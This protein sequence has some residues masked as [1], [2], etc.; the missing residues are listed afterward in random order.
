MQNILN[1]LTQ[2]LQQD[3]RLVIDGKLVKNKIVELALALD[4]S[5]IKLLLK[6]ASI[7]KHF[8]REVEGVLV[9]DKVE[10]QKFVSNK[11]F[12]PDSY[13]SFK[14]KIGLT[15]NGEYLT[16]AKE[17]VLVWPYKDCVLEGGQ[18][19][20]DQKRKE[21]FWNTT[22]A[23]DEIDRL[24]S[25]K[26]LTNFKR[27]DSN[28][29]HKAS[30]ITT[31][32][33]FILKGNNLLVIESLKKVFS[34]QV[35]LIYIDPPYNTGSDSFQYND[36][37]TNS[38]WLTFL[39]N[40]LHVA[41]ELMKD[42]GIIIIQINDHNQ[43]YLKCLMDEIFGR[44]NFINL[45]SIKTKSP[46]GFKTVNLGL[47]ETAEYLL[48]YG[49]NKSL[50]KYIP[51]YEFSGY[52]ENY[53]GFVKNIKDTP[54]AWQIDDLRKI[55]CREEGIDPDK[56]S[57]PYNKLKEKI[58]DMFYTNRLSK[59]ALENAE[60]VFRLTAIGDDAGKE[61]LEAKKQS[62]DNPEHVIEVKRKGLETRYI[63]NGQEMAFYSKKIR[64]IDGKR[65][66]TT[67]LTNIWTDISWEGIA[68][69]GGVKLKK[70][71]KPE[72]L[73]RRI[74]EMSTEKGDLVLDFY[75][76]SGTT[77]A[78]AHK[79]NRRYIGVEQ[80]D[81]GDNDVVSRMVNVING[82]TTGISKFSEW[83]GGGSFVYAELKKSNAEF[84]GKIETAKNTKELEKIWEQ[85]QKTGFLSYRID[86]KTINK[87]KSEFGQLTLDEQ[88]QF[89]IELL[90]KNQLYVNYSEIDD[91]D[92]N[93]SEDDKKLNRQFYSL[94]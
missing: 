56:V 41:K 88:K 48:M 46:S 89:L 24:L 18:T 85:M 33:N 47:F 34:G 91:K 84:C 32:D 37:F 27:Y 54:D 79:L 68:S 81:Y 53:S 80:L 50:F 61:T 52:D 12:L 67:M 77:T 3:K 63:L 71:K 44:E 57:R 45:I 38:T 55:L 62:I 11:Q 30:T 20:E 19:K 1:E 78:V 59:L 87:N 14:N 72:K 74:I 58:G 69:E 65:V 73:L 22:L 86:P 16:E 10:F 4:E 76:G 5:L 26:V 17:V 6:N 42:S 36:N 21:I 60:S 94:K 2:C 92:F 29:G 70:G 15:A 23:P 40:R 7:R 9:F 93:L 51:Q 39:K 75:V 13:T 82:D 49:K 64:E 31:E 28:G 43:G 83:K 90:D 25:P 8:F 66:P 35:K